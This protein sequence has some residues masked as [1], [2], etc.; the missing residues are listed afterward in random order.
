MHINFLLL[1]LTREDGWTDYVDF[2]F[3]VGH[4][5]LPWVFLRKLLS[6]PK[7]SFGFFCKMVEKNSNE[8]FG[9]CS[10]YRAYKSLRM[11]ICN[12]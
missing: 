2:I 5:G 6:W 4:S 1:L 7:S 11:K 12:Q 8:L 9:Q 10:T 3:K